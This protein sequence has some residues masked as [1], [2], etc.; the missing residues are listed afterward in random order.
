MEIEENGEI[1]YPDSTVSFS[2]EPGFELAGE[3]I[4]SCKLED[5]AKSVAWSESPPICRRLECPQVLENETIENGDIS[6]SNGNFF[7]STC[8][9]EC[10][11]GYKLLQAGLV[12]SRC[13]SSQTWTSTLSICA[14]MECK[15]P[16]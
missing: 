7:D 9:V 2:C 8:R 3:A 14:Q 1:F 4:I 12:E 6:C 16:R 11:E 5:D 15:T 10:N 13:Q